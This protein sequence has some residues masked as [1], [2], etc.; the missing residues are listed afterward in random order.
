LSTFGQVEVWERTWRAGSKNLRPVLSRLE[1]DVRGCSRRLQR[2]LTDFGAD[3]AF[4]PAAAK[5]GEHYGVEV[6]AERVR[7]VSLHHAAQMARRAKPE[8]QTTLAARGPD[9]IVA[10]ADGTMLPIVDTSAAPPGADRRKHRVVFWQEARVVA[11]R[12]L[13]E[14][15]THYDATLGEV[16]EAGCRWSQVAG[17]AGWAVNTRVHAVGDG[18]PW[19]AAQANERFGENSRYLLDLYHVCDYLAAVWPANKAEVHRH[20]DALKAGKLDAVLDALRE[21][22]EPSEA[23]E[24]EAPARAALRYLENRLDQLD[25]ASALR[26]GL[27][28]GSGLIESA[29]RHLLQSRLKLAGAWWTRAHAHNMTQ[30]RVTRANGLWADY[31]Q[32]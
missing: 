17:A 21:R 32:N 16:A 23:P 4:A 6:N 13:G 10:E 18:A 20:R 31:W 9:W 5:V 12:A 14:T 2:V 28:V 3:E 30:L 24:S 29:H 11:A 7:Q 25:Y 15:T 22:L 19:L 1:V 27:P 8:A 26:E